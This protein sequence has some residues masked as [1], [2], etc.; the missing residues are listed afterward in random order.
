[1]EARAARRVEVRIVR[2][3]YWLLWWW[4]WWWEE[5]WFGL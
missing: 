1:M 3:A 2:L 5:E 4:W